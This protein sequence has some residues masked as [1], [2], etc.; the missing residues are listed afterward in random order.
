MIIVQ[1]KEKWN[2]FDEDSFAS[3][4]DYITHFVFND[5][6]D[7]VFHGYDRSSLSEMEPILERGYL[8]AYLSRC[9]HLQS[10]YVISSKK[11]NSRLFIK[12]LPNGQGLEIRNFDY[13]INLGLYDKL[14]KSVPTMIWGV[15]KLEIQ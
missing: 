10:E 8:E 2:S 1:D 9:V 6:D 15:F 7:I 13:H 14:E 12:L 3:F 5:L 4:L 11:L